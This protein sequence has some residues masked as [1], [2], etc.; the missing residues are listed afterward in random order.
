ML[1]LSDT[2]NPEKVNRFFDTLNPEKA[3]RFF[4]WNLE[5][6]TKM[7]AIYDSCR[8][9]FPLP[10]DLPPEVVDVL[11]KVLVQTIVGGSYGEAKHDERMEYGTNL[12][13]HANLDLPSLHP[14]FASADVEN[15]DMYIWTGA[16]YAYADYLMAQPGF[17]T[18]TSGIARDICRIQHPHPDFRAG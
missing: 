6:K 9:K 3:K 18:T 1:T 14:F 2:L 13:R 7:P 12:V 11:S 17:L 16:T 5:L 8:F 10:E 15:G 4:E